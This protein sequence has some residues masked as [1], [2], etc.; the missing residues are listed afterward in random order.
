MSNNLGQLVQTPLIQPG[1]K[2][3]LNWPWIQFLSGLL[4]ASP[5]VSFPSPFF[6][7]GL[8]VYADNATALAGG[9]KVGQLYRTGADPDVV[10]VVH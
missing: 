2:D 7:T 4:M 9:L 6:I 3:L 8:S 5:N 1:T 10:C